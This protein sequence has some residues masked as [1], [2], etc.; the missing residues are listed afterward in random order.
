MSKESEITERITQAMKRAIAKAIRA[1]K[2][3]GR[4]IVI[5]KNGEVVE[6][7]ADE[8]EREFNNSG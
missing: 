4:P 1:H 2:E 7:K 8:I 6:L 3:A 5:W